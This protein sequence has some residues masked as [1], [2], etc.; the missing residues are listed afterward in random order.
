L[1]R[2][3]WGDPCVFQLFGI[4]FL[5][6]ILSWSTVVS[7]ESCPANRA[8]YKSQDGSKTFETTHFAMLRFFSCNNY[9]EKYCL[10][11]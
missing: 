7:A 4:I 6:L 3:P 10:G 5:I 9:E 2:G 11:V 1:V 8:I